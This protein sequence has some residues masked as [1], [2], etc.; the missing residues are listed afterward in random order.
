MAMGDGQWAMGVVAS[1]AS[2]AV[3]LC[4]MLPSMLSRCLAFVVLSV[5]LT[6]AATAANARPDSVIDLVYLGGPDCPYCRK[7]EA[8]E[9]PRLRQMEEFKHIRFTHIP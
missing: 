5:L 9:L 4:C 1:L 2:L 6:P 7:W 8:N 3:K